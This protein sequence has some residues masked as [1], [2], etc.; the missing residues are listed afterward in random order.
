MKY[1]GERR[2]LPGGVILTGVLWTWTGYGLRS[3]ESHEGVSA[4]GAKRVAR[5]SQ[6]KGQRKQLTD[7]SVL[8]AFEAGDMGSPAFFTL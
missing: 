1:P 8:F 7:G 5:I 3:G 2:C 4:E 6:A